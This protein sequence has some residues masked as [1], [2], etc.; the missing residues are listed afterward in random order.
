MAAVPAPQAADAPAAGECSGVESEKTGDYFVRFV[1][2]MFVM[3]VCMT[4]EPVIG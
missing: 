2:F 4:L 3:S 1:L